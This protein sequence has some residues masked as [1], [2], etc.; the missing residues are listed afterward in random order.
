LLAGSEPL[1]FER[2][3]RDARAAGALTDLQVLL[4]VGRALG[5][6]DGELPPSGALASG[7]GETNSD[8]LAAYMVMAPFEEWAPSVVEGLAAGRRGLPESIRRFLRPC[9]GAS[10]CRSALGEA[11]SGAPL[12][13]NGVDRLRRALVALPALLRPSTALRGAAAAQRLFADREAP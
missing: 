12:P 2:T 7:S 4:T 9:S 3:E 10:E 1:E 13:V 5:F 6:L 8:A 11:R